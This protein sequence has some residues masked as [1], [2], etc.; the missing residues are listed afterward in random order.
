MKYAS[1]GPKV[2]SVRFLDSGN[3][4]HDDITDERLAFVQLKLIRVSATLSSI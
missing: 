3:G 2:D 1:N 4:N